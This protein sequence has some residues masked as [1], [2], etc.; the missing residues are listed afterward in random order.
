MKILK[1]LKSEKGYQ[2][3]RVTLFTVYLVTTT[4]LIVPGI[5]KSAAQG[6]IG[7]GL[8]SVVIINVLVMLFAVA[9]NYE[10][11]VKLPKEELLD[12]SEIEY[13]KYKQ[14]ARWKLAAVQ[15]IALTAFMSV[16]TIPGIEP[17]LVPPYLT[18]TLL[19]GLIVV[20]IVIITTYQIGKR[21]FGSEARIKNKFDKMNTVKDE[22]KQAT[23][24]DLK[25]YNIFQILLLLFLGMILCGFIGGIPFYFLAAWIINSTNPS[26]LGSMSSEIAQYGAFIYTILLLIIMMV[27]GVRM[28][29]VNNTQ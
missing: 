13:L 22:T 27:F 20:E 24:G 18:P 28:K 15:I 1:I 10:W 5:K 19:I 14:F 26:A 6:V 23:E 8:I 16:F 17:K 7:F 2:D 3:L 29:F 21:Y 12:E 11:F 9:M 25:D 4:L